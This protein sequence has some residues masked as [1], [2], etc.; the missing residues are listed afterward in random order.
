MIPG[1]LTA[2]GGGHIFRATATPDG[3]QTDP[4]GLAPSF[5]AMFPAPSTEAGEP[6]VIAFHEA[7]RTLGA[8]IEQEPV[9][10]PWPGIT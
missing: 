10:D 2:S 1:V 6:W 9:P 8:K 7:A 4:P 3:W 5:D